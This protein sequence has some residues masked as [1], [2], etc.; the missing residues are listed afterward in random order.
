MLNTK[1]KYEANVWLTGTVLT[2]IY[3]L[4]GYTIVYEQL[5]QQM[6][7]TIIL[8]TFDLHHFKVCTGK[9]SSLRFGTFL[10]SLSA[11][12]ILFTEQQTW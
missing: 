2:D 11:A 8:Q 10:H 1:Q 7:S 4:N 9:W 5:C 6:D 3:I 12:V